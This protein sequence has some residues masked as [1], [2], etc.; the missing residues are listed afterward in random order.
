VTALPDVRIVEEGSTAR[1]VLT[2]E[3]DV[4]IAAKLITHA[5]RLVAAAPASII[6]DLSGTTFLDSSGV[7]ALVS[8]SNAAAGAGLG[9]VQLEA[10]PPNVMRVLEIVGL[11]DAFEVLP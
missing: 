9:T 6:V 3:I 2:G 5:E 8:L 7:G 11:K 10:G 1:L 4:S